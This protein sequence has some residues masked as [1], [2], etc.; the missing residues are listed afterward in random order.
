MAHCRQLLPGDLLHFPAVQTILQRQQLP[1]LLEAE[2]QL[3]CPLDEAEALHMFGCV[4]PDTTQGLSRLGYEAAPLVIAD[5]FHIDSGLSGKSTDGAPHSH[6]DSVV[7][8][9]PRITAFTG[10]ATRFGR[11]PGYFKMSDKP[12]IL[13]A[14]G[15]AVALSALA[16]AFGACCVA[17]WAVALLGVGGAVMLARLAG[18]QSPVVAVTLLLVGLGFWYAYRTRSSAKGRTCAVENR[19]GLRIAVWIGALIVISVDIASYLPR[20]ASFW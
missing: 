3:L 19:K 20:L 4:V 12:K 8:Y 9:G 1:D 13:G 17:P 14:T 7:D 10:M 15:G 6:I 16:L 11:T 2:A 18:L 5:G